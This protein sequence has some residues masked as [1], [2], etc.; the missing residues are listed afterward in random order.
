[1]LFK[2]GAHKSKPKFEC[3]IKVLYTDSRKRFIFIK[4]WLFYKKKSIVIKYAA[5]YIYIKNRL[6]K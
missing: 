4:L 3:L 1:M 6:T 5:L 2:F